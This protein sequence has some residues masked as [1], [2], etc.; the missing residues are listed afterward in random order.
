[1]K[2]SKNIRKYTNAQNGKPKRVNSFIFNNPIT[3]F[4]VKHITLNTS[5]IFT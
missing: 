2:D 3:D 4:C 5:S 1:M